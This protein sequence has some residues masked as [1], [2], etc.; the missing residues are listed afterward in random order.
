LM[1]I[2]QGQGRELLMV[3][4]D[5]ESGD[6]DVDYDESFPEDSEW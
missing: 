1:Q 6:S 5:S 2:G 4:D 3:L